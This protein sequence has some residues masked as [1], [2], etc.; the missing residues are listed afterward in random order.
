MVRIAHTA[1]V[2]WRGLSRHDEYRK[3]FSYF[4]DD[5]R[6]KGIDHIFIGG[7]IFHTKTTG[8]SP[9]YIDQ[10]TW[11]L[12]ELSTVA[13]VHLILGN[14]DGNL[15]NL[16][17][18]DAVSPIVAALGND[19]VH[20]YKKSG[21][22]EFH[23]GYNWCVFSLF[24][25]EGW[26]NV[27]PSM[28]MVNIACYHGPVH[29]S[30]SETGWNIE[31]GT[32]VEFFEG[33]DFALLGD[34]HK[35]Q[36]L[37]F[38]NNKPWIGYPGTPLQQNYAEDIDHGYL[39]WDI[40]SSKEWSVSFEK[41]PNIKPFV[42]LN[43]DGSIENLEESS[44]N[45]PMGTRFRIRS[46]DHISQKEIQQ[47]GSLLT[48]KFSATE[49]TYKSEFVIDKSAIKTE[50]SSL[51]KSDLRSPDVVLKLIKEHHKNSTVTNEMW[52][53]IGELTKAV[54]TTVSSQEETTRNSKWSLRH[55]SFD[56]MFTYGEGNNINFDGL[57]G[58]VGIFGSN[59][60]GK[61]SIVGSIMYSLFNTT[62]RGP[63][64]N[65]HVCNVRKPYCSSRAIINHN[66]TDYVIE[67]QTTKSENKK[68]VVSASTAL[69][70]YRIKEDGE[71]EELNG[72]QRNDTEKLVRNLIG[73]SEDF[74]LTSLSAQGEINQFIMQGSSKRRTILSRFLDLDVFDKMY[75]V[76][77]KE[78]SGIKYQLKNYPE[79]NW[80][81]L[82]ESN[83]SE[84]VS[85]IE[86]IG[87]IAATIDDKRL[88]ISHLQSELHKHGNSSYVTKEQIEL[89]QNKVNQLEKSCENCAQNI[90]LL[91]NEISNFRSKIATI[92]DVKQQNDIMGLRTKKA[93]FKKLEDS[94]TVLRHTF[95]K[96]EETL[97]RYQKSL[98]ILDEVP[99]GDQYSSCK[100]I[101]D[102]Y[103]NKEK[104]SKQEHQTASAKSNLENVMS[105][106]KSLKEEGELE[107][108]E[109]L[110]K[111][112]ELESKIELDISKKE[113]E[114]AKSKSSCENLSIELK[115]ARD[116]LDILQ[117]SMN[118]E[119][120]ADVF[121]IKSD[122]NKLNNDIKLLDAERFDAIAKKGKLQAE[123]D[124][125][126]KEKNQR[127]SL[128]E[129]LKIHDLMSS[130]FSKKGIPL[131]VTKSQLPA[132]NAE[133]AKIL[134]GIVEF[135]IELE[136]DE[137]SDTTEIFIN[138]GDS[139]RVIELCSGMEKTIAS[140]AVRVAMINVSSLP[141]PDIFIID[142]GFGT[143]D[144][145]AVEACNRLLVSLKRYFKTIV[146][147]THVDGIKDV[148]D[149]VLEISKYEKDAKITYGET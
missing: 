126:A 88:E 147:I 140:L 10:C 112:I 123:I 93:I 49:I 144:D 81:E 137:D 7:D 8:I 82:I 60:I 3:V 122:L 116:R 84:L 109:K 136:N 68:G 128:L 105:A 87:T 143:L 120:N 18:Q 54:L 5:C 103:S 149:T 17:R 134:H 111:L 34:I 42:T 44:K 66:G 58:I 114:I 115:I 46:S 78:A 107:K 132:I 64:K 97:K 124:A 104:L 16:S 56:N 2:H 37:S 100:F 45:F 91:E 139:K 29:G 146:V 30:V 53:K 76:V 38:R 141:R 108:L 133:I 129:D 35:Q 48:S 50:T 110:E 9:E 70:F 65:I 125:A 94:L 31:E 36:F 4:I 86:R 121:S 6:L 90:S 89:Q 51:V 85:I 72:E 148:V 127:G 23:P 39:L 80:D 61:S 145:S 142:E 131:V 99:C 98:K 113:T 59:R 135:S 55:L 73:N 24:D 77:S 92:H 32:G 22:Y 27:R 40:K 11:W 96:E 20:L 13:H 106:L 74:L 41:L 102:A 130:A 75:E 71:A 69:N 83:K 118:D 26:K 79:K 21:V 1:D 95:E 47:I 19:R 138:Y 25:E 12:N 63:M 117:K 119:E 15:V 67:R 14:H 62:D 33:Y 101:K 28:G 57:N 52:S 43:W